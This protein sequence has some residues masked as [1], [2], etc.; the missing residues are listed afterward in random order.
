MR[1]T[2]LTALVGIAGALT[3]ALA[4]CSSSTAETAA[5]AAASAPAAASAAASAP[6]AMLTLPQEY[7]DKGYVSVASDLAYPPLDMTDENGNPTGFDI[8][9]AYAMGDLFG[10]E[11][12][13]EKQEFDAMIPA[14]QSGK[15]DIIMSTMTDNAERQKVLSF[16]DYYQGGFNLLVKKGNPEGITTILDL[17]GKNVGIQSGTSQR[18]LIEETAK[19]C[20]NGETIEISEFPSDVDAQNA[21]RAGKVVAD[22]TD[23]P[24]AVYTAQTAG[25]GEYFEVVQDPE[26]PSGYDAAPVGVGILKENT[27]LVEAIQAALTELLNNGTYQALL[28]QYGLSAYAVS[29]ITVNAG[30]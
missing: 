13:V 19:Q 10:V 14:L 12:R 29:E 30:K 24:V 21:V 1:K 4:G 3:L 8:D 17:C 2:R 26:F 22:V 5:T 23:A 28:D 18:S 7:I 11:F 25:N 9:L 27:A 6:A 20:A 15:R 16:V